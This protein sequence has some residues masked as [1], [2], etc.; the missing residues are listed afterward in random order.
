MPTI[1]NGVELGFEIALGFVLFGV[2]CVI[3]LVLLGL[4]IR[5]PIWF[6]ETVV[7][8]LRYAF[9]P[10][11]RKAVRDGIAYSIIGLALVIA[12]IFVASLFFRNS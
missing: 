7:K 11:G 10:K 8:E 6:Y 4:L 2:V 3:G 12:L 1:G 5:I 9:S